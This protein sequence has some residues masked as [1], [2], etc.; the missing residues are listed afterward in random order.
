[1][2][3]TTN[4]IR[5]VVIVV[6]LIG[7]NAVAFA[8]EAAAR[9]S[10]EAGERAY[11]LGEFPKAID[12]FKAAYDEWPEPAILFNLAQTYRQ[13]GN[14]KQAQFFYK[15]FLAL[16]E[17]DTK[18]PIRPDLRTEVEKRIAELEDCLK[19]ELASQPPSGLDSATAQTASTAQTKT[20]T[21]PDNATTTNPT[22]PN[23]E[24][25]DTSEENVDQDRD[26]ETDTSDS[27]P[28]TSDKPSVVTLRLEVGAAKLTAGNLDPGMQFA[29]ELLAGYPLTLAPDLQV[30]LG[31]AFGFSV[32]PYTT[33]VNEAGSMGLVAVVGN[34]SP[35][36]EVTPKLSV[37]ADVGLGALV[38][39]GLEKMGNPFTEMGSPATGALATFHVRAGVG[40]DYAVMRNFVVTVTPLAYGY[41][42]AP[43]GFTDT[44]E[45]VTEV[46][47]VAGI[48]YRR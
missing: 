41:S 23:D 4:M 45:S 40:V 21:T 15:R 10:F 20:K 33:D 26:G 42:P 30:E 46:A 32:V 29:G 16:K 7:W 27:P 18:K 9:K 3:V 31:A 12:L 19:R 11:N 47:F 35:R 48:G 37:R 34:V 25:A 43:T 14:C 6:G 28:P 13:L 38:V 39:T 24:T 8:D 5:A 44:V 1:M 17:Q 22:K 2:T 36:Y